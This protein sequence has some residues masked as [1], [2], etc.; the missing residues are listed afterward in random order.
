MVYLKANLNFSTH[1]AQAGAKLPAW[2]WYYNPAQSF[3]LNKEFS[4]VSCIQLT[5]GTQILVNH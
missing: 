3:L 2:H 5:T 4:F 1:A